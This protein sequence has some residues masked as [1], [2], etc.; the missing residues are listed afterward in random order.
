MIFENE[1]INVEHEPSEIPWVKVF[2][3]RNIREFSQ[4]S[5]AEKIEI[6]R[7]IDVSERLMLRYFNADNKEL[8][9]STQHAIGDNIVC[10]INIASFGNI[11]PRVHWH[12]MA[13]FEND[14]YF[15]E[16][17]WGEKQREAS[18]I[19]PSFKVFYKK[20]GEELLVT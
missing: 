18:L 9:G 17:M 8:N 1:L 6:L 14:S 5:D 15:P 2:I 3:K 20:L 11:L 12:I 19:L 13:R 10:K 16:P 7:V 4:C